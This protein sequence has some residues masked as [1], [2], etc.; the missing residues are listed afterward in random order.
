M[1]F[2]KFVVGGAACAA[3]LF[4]S[5]CDEALKEETKKIS[6]EFLEPAISIPAGNT[7]ETLVKVEPAARASEV[8]IEVA[9]ESVV[10][11]GNKEITDEGIL[12]TLVSHSGFTEVLN[13]LL[14]NENADV[15][16]TGSNSRF[17]SSDI[18]T[19]FRGRGYVINL[20]P[21]SFSEY[22]TAFD[23]SIDEAWE[24]YYTYGGLPLILSLED[25]TAKSEYLSEL[26]RTVYL[27]DIKERHDIR[28]GSDFSDL[29]SV[30]ASSIGSPANPLKLAN[31]FKSTK[32]STISSATVSRYIDYLCDAFITEKSVRFD[33]KGK[34]YIGS[35]SK[36]YFTDIGIRNAILGFRQQEE[37][38]IMENII[39]NELRIRGFRVD[40][41]N[42]V[43]RTTDK[44]GKTIRKSLEVDFVANS[45]NNR[46]YIQSALDMPTREKVEQETPSLREIGDSFK[47]IV[48]V[49]DRIKPR[50]DDFG[51]LTIGL[52]DFLLH[53]ENFGL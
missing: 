12:L 28:H 3:L 22:V 9:A 42:L 41:G 49:K 31:T 35:L 32:K 21:L 43:Q 36:Y 26:Y 17:L 46:Y 44:Q 8:T 48:V 14:H 20:H 53:P 7:A 11:I 1:D 34:R 6:V 38:H 13:S 2:R 51:I 50:R 19:D 47:K 5:G 4:L 27:S 37:S 52:F 45:G 16:V 10:S 23:G 15:Y 29:V 40:V 39:F 24:E 33:L 18:A 30:L 25:D